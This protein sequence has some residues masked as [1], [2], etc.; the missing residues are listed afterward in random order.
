[1]DWKEYFGRAYFYWTAHPWLAVSTEYQF[2]RFERDKEFGLGIKDV[3]THRVPLGVNF[4]HPSGFSAQLK[5]TYVDQKGTF[6]PQRSPPDFFQSG[7]DQ[8][9]VV[10]AAIRYRLPKRWGFITIGVRNLFD[11]NFKFQDTDVFQENAVSPFIQPDRLIF[12]RV[13]LF[14]NQ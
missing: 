14:L 12:A 8:F 11:E 10:D 7:S 4:F 5:T 13:T 1:V 6:H 2:E 3:D 9:W